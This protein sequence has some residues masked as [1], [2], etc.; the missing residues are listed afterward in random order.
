MIKKPT[1][2]KVSGPTGISIGGDQIFETGFSFYV[3]AAS[4]GDGVLDYLISAEL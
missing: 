4:S 2:S 3:N 1:V